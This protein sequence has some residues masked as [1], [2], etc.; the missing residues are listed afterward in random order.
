MSKLEAIRTW[1]ADHDSPIICFVQGAD[2]EVIKLAK[3]LLQEQLAEVILLGD[4][5]EIYDQCRIYRVNESLL[6]GVI[7]PA[8]HAEIEYYTDLYR[9]QHPHEEPKKAGR[10]VQRPEILAQL[11]QADGAVDLVIADLATW[12]GPGL[13]LT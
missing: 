9:E 2:H 11:M 8:D 4:E 1:C 5:L 12:S 10:A 3:I 6:Y 7:N 13:P